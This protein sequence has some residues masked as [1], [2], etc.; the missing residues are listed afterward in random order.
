[1]K[2]PHNSFSHYSGLACCLLL[3]PFIPSCIDV[4]VREDES[5]AGGWE[6]TKKK[7]ALE[8]FQWTG[9]LRVWMKNQKIKIK[10]EEGEGS[11]R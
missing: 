11:G 6:L 2:K 5:S 9:K 1:M 10:I 8:V 7:S 4:K 3:S